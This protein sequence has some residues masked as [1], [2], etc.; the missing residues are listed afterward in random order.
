MTHWGHDGLARPYWRL[1]W[2]AQPGWSISHAGRNIPLEPERILLIA[3]ETVY[4]GHGRSSTAHVFLHFICDGLS[5]D[6]LTGI[7]SL[8][9]IGAFPNLLTELREQPRDPTCD[10][11]ALACHALGRLPTTAYNQRRS[12]GPIAAAQNLAERY[13]HRA[14]TNEELARAAKMHV[15]AFIRRFRVDTGETPRQWHL[16]RRID[17]ACVALEA[18]HSIDTVA[19]HHG[20]CDRHHLTRVFTRLRGCGPATYR[21][22]A[23][24]Q[25]GNT[26]LPLKAL[27]G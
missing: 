24:I 9:C 8:P 6:P 19:E 7:H 5:G 13:L 11:I 17:A 12:S 3:P 25:P 22:S 14:V 20:F 4:R 21:K 1:Y 26:P 27:P 23:A 18:G 10:A 15:N 16:R 2:N